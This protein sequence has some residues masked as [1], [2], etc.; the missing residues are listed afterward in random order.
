MCTAA[1]ACTQ[2]MKHGRSSGRT[3]VG[4]I[5]SLHTSNSSSSIASASGPPAL[6]LCNSLYALLSKPL[7]YF[8]V[9]F[10]VRQSFSVL[11]LPCSSRL[12]FAV[13]VAFV[14]YHSICPTCWLCLVSRRTRDQ[15]LISNSALCARSHR[16]PSRARG[17]TALHFNS[18]RVV[19]IVT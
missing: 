9:D 10:A 2:A 16:L 5:Q 11:Q 12:Y 6:P 18:Y 15:L 17:C 8:C 13:C 7:L 19:P 14:P 3:A 4:H 1:N